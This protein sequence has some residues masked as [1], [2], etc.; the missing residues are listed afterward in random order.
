MMNEELQSHSYM[1][2]NPDDWV[3]G[4]V[5]N[6]VDKTK[7]YGNAKYA[8]YR[9]DPLEF[10]EFVIPAEIAE[11]IISNMIKAGVE[12]MKNIPDESLEEQYQHMWTDR[13]DEFALCHADV[14]GKYF[15]YYKPSQKMVNVYS[16]LRDW[17]VENMLKA[18]V[19]VWDERP[20]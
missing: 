18:G 11:T 19:D 13:K 17:C 16:H 15:F 7:W 4:P 9:R 8:P 2:E 10:V 5:L 3:L 14:V 20:T 12:I 1:W 6:W